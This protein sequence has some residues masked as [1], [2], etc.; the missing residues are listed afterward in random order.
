MRSKIVDQKKSKL[1]DYISKL[2][3]QELDQ[4]S[5]QFKL[6]DNPKSTTTGGNSNQLTEDNL[7]KL[8]DAKL[9]DARPLTEKLNSIKQ[10]DDLSVIQSVWGGADEEA[11]S[12]V[13]STTNKSGSM[14]SVGASY[15]SYLTNVEKQLRDEKEARI[16]LEEEVNRLRH[17]NEELSEYIRG[18]KSQFSGDRSQQHK[19]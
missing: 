6:Y 15:Y 3:E 1:L 10:R 12:S 4:L 16:K 13:V 8:R 2:D 19:Y 14:K 17:K 9:Y 7:E 5:R 11:M 18:N